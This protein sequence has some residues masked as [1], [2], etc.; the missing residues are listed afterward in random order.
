MRAIPGAA[1][2]TWCAWL[3]TSF[4]ASAMFAD[5]TTILTT[6]A[7]MTWN[8]GFCAQV[9]TMKDLVASMREMAPPMGG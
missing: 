7:L 1:L 2:R 8:A 5:L 6:D 9:L 4:L 3:R